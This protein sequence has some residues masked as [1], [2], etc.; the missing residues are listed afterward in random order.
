MIPNYKELW[1]PYRK[2]GCS[3]PRMTAWVKKQSGAS[4]EILTQVIQ[5]LFLE[6]EEGR[7]FSVKGC[8]CGCGM[9]NAHTAINHYILKEV[10]KLN[11][12]MSLKYWKALE[13]QQAVR[14]EKHV[15][16]HM[17]RQ[18]RPWYKKLLRIGKWQ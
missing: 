7:K 17:K 18:A 4:E 2:D 5:D 8:D 15:K 9:T 14:I 6:L 3:L 11:E 12:T 16:R 10:L 13:A 1:E